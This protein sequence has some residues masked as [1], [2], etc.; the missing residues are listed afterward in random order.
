M[1]Q[2]LFKIESISM[3]ID[4]FFLK[5]S[6]LI[7]RFNW[8]ELSTAVFHRHR[9]RYC[10]FACSVCGCWIFA[11]NSVGGVRTLHR[12]YDR[13]EHFTLVQR[14]NSLVVGGSRGD[15]YINETI[16]RLFIAFEHINSKVQVSKPK[17]NHY[18]RI[19]EN[20]LKAYLDVIFHIH[21]FFDCFKVR[22]I[23]SA[24][25]LLENHS[26]C[27]KSRAVWISRATPKSNRN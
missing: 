27:M 10:R 17:S 2:F 19:R 26:Y 5:W 23:L 11:P 7:E 4:Y 22:K 15:Y 1:I 24:D 18:G 16:V 20:P 3:L 6:Q 21:Q 8:I 14:Y 9:H 13:V 12:I 25:F